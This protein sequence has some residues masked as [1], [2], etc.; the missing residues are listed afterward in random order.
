MVSIGLLHEEQDKR[1]N[2]CPL[3]ARLAERSQTRVNRSLIYREPCLYEQAAAV[4]GQDLAGD[5]VGGSEVQNCLG[6]FV[7]CTGAV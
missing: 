3:R 7:S 4:D 6:D 5:K 1:G 2:G